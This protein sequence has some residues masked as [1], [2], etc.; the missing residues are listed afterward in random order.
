MNKPADTAPT[1]K[2]P[3]RQAL[4]VKELEATQCGPCP[5]PP[6]AVA[7]GK[8]SCGIREVTASP[9]VGGVLWGLWLPFTALPAQ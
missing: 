9:G 1:P 6:A 3:E 8:L 2:Q 7:V 5:P 4:P